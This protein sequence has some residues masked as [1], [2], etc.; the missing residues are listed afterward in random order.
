LNASE[1]GLDHQLSTRSF[2]G[3]FRGFAK[4]GTLQTLIKRVI[5]GSH[6]NAAKDSNCKK[7][8]HR[9]DRIIDSGCNVDL[10]RAGTALITVVVRGATL[11]TMPNPRITIETRNCQ[12]DPL[13]TVTAITPMPDAAIAGPMTRGKRAPKRSSNPPAQRD[14]PAIKIVKGRKAAPASVAGYPCTAVCLD[15][16]VSPQFVAIYRPPSIKGIFRTYRAVHL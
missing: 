3:V 15:P 4:R 8:R 9:R 11:T 6:R 5:E 10:M 2:D 14:R 1:C 7:I 13:V 12:Y 16:S